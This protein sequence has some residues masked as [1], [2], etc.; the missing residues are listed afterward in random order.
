[1]K[2]AGFDAKQVRATVLASLMRP[3]DDGLARLLVADGASVNLEAADRTMTAPL[4]QAVRLE[5]TA[6]VDALLGQR[7]ERAPC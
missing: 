4:A 3:G 5:Q 1:M 2:E 6:L 7:R